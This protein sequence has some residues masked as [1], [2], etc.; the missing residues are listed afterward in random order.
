MTTRTFKFK[1]TMWLKRLGHKDLTRW[2]TIRK[3]LMLRRHCKRC[4]NTATLNVEALTLKGHIFKYTCISNK[5]EI[6]I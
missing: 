3:G 5:S 6:C 1:A 4:H 2:Y